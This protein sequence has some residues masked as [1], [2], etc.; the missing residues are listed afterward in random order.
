MVLVLMRAFVNLDV[1][2][3]LVLVVY[4]NVPLRFVFESLEVVLIL[5][6]FKSFYCCLR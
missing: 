6:V 5:L 1:Q 2:H 3:R 4:L